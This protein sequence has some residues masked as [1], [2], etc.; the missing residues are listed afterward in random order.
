MSSQWSEVCGNSHVLP[1]DNMDG[2][3]LTHGA[4]TQSRV[5]VREFPHGVPRIITDPT[6]KGGTHAQL[7]QGVVIDFMF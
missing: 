1:K 3:S 4:Q 7:P 6:P 2:S 5:V